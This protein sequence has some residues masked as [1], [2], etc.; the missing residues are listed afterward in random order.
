MAA[1]TNEFLK[2]ISGEQEII[3]DAC[4]GT[5]SIADSEEIFTRFL[6]PSF[7]DAFFDKTGKET[8]EIS[9][10]ISEITK[11]ST[12]QKIFHSLEIDPENLRLTQHQI[13]NFCEKYPDKFLINGKPTL[14]LFK[15]GSSV[16]VASIARDSCGLRIY[17]NDLY[18]GNVGPGRYNVMPSW[19][20]AI[21]KLSS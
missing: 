10:E 13:I 14:F 5:R 17:R 3:I 21:P 12:L 7:K 15:M 18:G 9:L 1:A 11:M 2:L 4:D 6:D 16:C 8:K 19:R 20:I